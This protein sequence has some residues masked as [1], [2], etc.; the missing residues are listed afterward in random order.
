MLQVVVDEYIKFL[1]S[2]KV[3]QDGGRR[4]T[5]VAYRNDLEQLSTFLQAREVESWS[6]V[7][8]E[9]MAAYMTEMHD[10][11]AYRPTTIARKLAAL[12]SFFRYMHQSG[13]I[14]ADPAEHFNPPPIERDLPHVLH[15]DQVERIFAQVEHDTPAGLR[16]F[17]MLHLL[18]STGIRTSEMVSLNVEHFDSDR[19]VV[20]CAGKQRGGQRER[21][22]PLSFE[23][24]EVML[25]YLEQSR[26]RFVRYTGEQ[27]LFLNHH[28]ERLTRQGF[29]L[30]I[31]GYARRS[32]ITELTPHMLRNS[33]ALMMLQ[34]GMEL[35]S[36][37]ELLGHAHI[38]TTLQYSHLARAQKNRQ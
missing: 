21:I 8:C 9:H 4:N 22:L 25:L 15:H 31:K 28:G 30:I 3:E 19:G 20:I 2:G 16:D 14:T 7:T 17:A 5:V 35:S 12:K 18:Y 11:Q 1:T 29:W 37:Q 13:I 23:S 6:Q 27:A 32:G 33:F 36:V 10:I 26:P 24:F 34:D 38:S